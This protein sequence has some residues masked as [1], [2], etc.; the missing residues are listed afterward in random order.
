M[1]PVDILSTALE[2]FS[3]VQLRRTHRLKVCAPRGLSS[4]AERGT[5]QLVT[6]PRTLGRSFAVCAAQDDGALCFGYV[7]RILA[8]TTN[9]IPIAIRKKEKNCP[10]VK[11]PTSDASGSRKF[12]QM[13]R[14]TA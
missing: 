4:R 1:H 11:A 7:G 8:T 10:R 13:M 14:K 9:A 5:S 12:S 6:H 3:G 2:G